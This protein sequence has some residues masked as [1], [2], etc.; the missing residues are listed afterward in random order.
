MLLSSLNKNK[1]FHGIE[2]VASNYTDLPKSSLDKIFELRKKVFIDRRKWDIESY[3]GGNLE[4]DEYDNDEAYYIYLLIN[5]CISG[6]VRLRPST[7]PTLMTGALKWL[8]ESS[9]FDESQLENSWEASRFFIT[10]DK[11]NFGAKKSF[12]VRIYALFISM[13]DFGLN[14]GVVNY[15]VVVDEM[16][17]R[18]LRM[19]GWPLNV[20][21]SGFGSL[22]EKVYYG[23]LPCC[24]KAV[25]DIMF[26]ANKN[27]ESCNIHSNFVKSSS[28]AMPLSLLA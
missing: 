12:D 2:V 6:C 7:S 15:E 17:R 18:V 16:M 14:R 24:Q 23:N 19:C 22:S 26:I 9:Q 21:N 11:I 8:K 13:I 28:C 4:Y 10:P 20:L 27:N 3:T 5:N 1:M 25:K